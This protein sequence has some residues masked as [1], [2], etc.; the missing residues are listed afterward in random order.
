MEQTEEWLA[1][2]LGDRCSTPTLAVWGWP[3]PTELHKQVGLDFSYCEPINQVLKLSK[4][5][6][7]SD[8]I[9]FIS[10]VFSLKQKIFSKLTSNPPHTNVVYLLIILQL[11]DFKIKIYCNA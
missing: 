3:S 7:L 4:C 11:K 2:E 9:I 1:S 10:I 6:L 8:N 5:T